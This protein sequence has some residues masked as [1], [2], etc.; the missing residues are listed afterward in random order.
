MEFPSN[1][2][3]DEASPEWMNKGDNAWQLTAATL[4]G[5]QT[6]P[7]L[8][9]LYGGMVKKKWAINS[10][11]MALYAFAAVMICWVGWGFQMAFGQNLVEFLGKPDHVTLDQKFLLDQAF[12]GYFPNATMVLFQFMFAAI[13]LVLIAGALLGRMNFVAWMLFVPLWLT[14]SYTIGA[15]SI[16]CP[17]GWLAKLGVIDF[18]GGYVIHLSAGV[19]GFTA[20]CWVGPRSRRDRER[21]PPNNVLMMLAGAG[22]LWMGWTGFNGGAPYVASTDSALAALNTHVCTAT[23][24]ITWLILDFSVFG[25][26]SIIGALQGMIT[27]L[28]CITPA[29]G[30]VQ[31]WAAII[32]GLISGSVPW[33]TMMILHHKIPL[34]NQVDDTFAVLHTHA[35]AGALGGILTGFFAVPKLS[36]LFFLVPDWEKYIGL[37]YGLQTGRRAAGFKQMGVQLL[38]IAFIVCLNIVTTSV[39]CLFIKLIVPLRMSE[40]ELEIGDEAVHGEIAYALWDDGEKYQMS[41]NNSVYDVDEF[42]SSMSKNASYELSQMV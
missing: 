27:G 34:L 28:V 2:A 29:A 6:V 31:C 26:P 39:I 9:I 22:L 17:D 13:T 20:A 10:A 21:F 30:V 41:K 38:G 11:F 15:Y 24:L 33:Y 8:M 36:R 5:L 23:S 14:F 7:G 42:P 19:A 16:W 1:L 37:A 18:A 4:V 32:M 12:L 40:E 3:A 25:K 35:I